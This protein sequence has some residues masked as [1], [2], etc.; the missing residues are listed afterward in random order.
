MSEEDARGEENVSGEEDVRGEEGFLGP[1]EALREGGPGEEGADAREPEDAWLE[2]MSTQVDLKEFGEHG[3]ELDDLPLPQLPF[4]EAASIMASSQRL[5]GLFYGL[6]H[7]GFT[8]EQA[9]WVV[10]DYLKQ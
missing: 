7:A 6:R 8:Q 5:Y 3:Q 1:E 2:W 10:G 9:I 4:D